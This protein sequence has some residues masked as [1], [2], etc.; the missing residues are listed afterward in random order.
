[1]EVTGNV[2]STLTE[3]EKVIF[4]NCYDF[5]LLTFQFGWFII[6]QVT[7]N[8]VNWDTTEKCLLS[9]LCDI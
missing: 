1:M 6:V 7:N 5:T 4:L 3:S 2:M 9:Y 8:N